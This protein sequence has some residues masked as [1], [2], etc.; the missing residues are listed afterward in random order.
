MHLLHLVPCW[1]D[2]PGVVLPLPTPIRAS[3][4]HKFMIR[5]VYSNQINN[6]IL[7]I[8]NDST[9]DFFCLGV[10]QQMISFAFEILSHE[11]LLLVNHC[12]SYVWM[13]QMW[14]ARSVLFTTTLG[15]L[16]YRTIVVIGQVDISAIVSLNR[17][18]IGSLDHW[19]IGSLEHWTILSFR[20]ITC[21]Y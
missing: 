14:N 13:D 2:S 6:L 18:T 8:W 15:L 5:C 16:N 1:D 10:I 17:W 4:I 9:N 7:L 3:T 19:A 20:Y 12:N 21:S 11:S